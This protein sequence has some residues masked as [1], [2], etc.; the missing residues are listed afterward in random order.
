M[1]GPDAR[2][3]ESPSEGPGAATFSAPHEITVDAEAQAFWRMRVWM[4]TA[5]VKQVLETSRLR[6]SLLVFLS[7]FFWIALFCLFYEG[8]HFLSAQI[9]HVATRAETVRA[10][11]NVFFVSLM[12]MLLLSSAIILYS[13]LFANPEASFLL[14]TPARAARI[15]LHKFQEAI[16]FSCWGF[17]LLGSPMLIAYGVEARAPWHY[18]ALMFPFML[19]FVYI[20]ARWGRC[21]AS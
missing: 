13:G 19:A 6:V 11:Y 9:G 10:V 5:S 14:T 1:H 17:V 20:P 4:V 7:V 21:Y 18:F 3:T 8:F 2:S 15:V 16:F 12:A